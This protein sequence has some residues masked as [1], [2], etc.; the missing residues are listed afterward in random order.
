M[1]TYM[2]TYVN[3]VWIKEYPHTHT[4]TNKKDMQ[5]YS[6]VIFTYNHMQQQYVNWIKNDE[7]MMI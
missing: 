7:N 1:Y 2:F 6:Y 3:I 4:N 5:L